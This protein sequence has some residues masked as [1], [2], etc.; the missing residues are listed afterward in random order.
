MVPMIRACFVRHRPY[1]RDARMDNQIRA[2]QSQGHRVD[3]L[4]TATPGQPWVADENGIRIYRLPALQ[5]RRGSK[6]R[7]ALEYATFW[8]TCLVALALLQARRGY[9]LVHV[10][11]LPDFLVWAAI[12]PKLLGARIIL[13]LRECTPEMYH[14]KF[15][16]AMDS[17]AMPWLI[18]LEQSSI[19]FTHLALTCTEQMRARFMER[20]ASR[21]K[22]AVMLN[23]ANPD[24][25]KDPVLPDPHVC[26]HGTLRV[27][28][29]GTITERYGHEV[30]IRAMQLVSREV[31][32]ARLIILGEGGGQHELEDLARAL[33]LQEIVTFCGF[34]PDD[35]LTRQL[36]TAHC[37][38]VPM[39][40]NAE[41]DLIHTYKMVEYMALGI[42]VVASRTTAL[43][44]YYGDECI[45][46]FESGDAADLARALL[47][48]HNDPAR[49]ARWARKALETYQPLAAPA[50]QAHYLE[51]VQALLAEE[52]SPAGEPAPNQALT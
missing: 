38:V 17:R 50:Q 20:G 25:F 46:F 2:L 1:P 43:E 49:R 5:R 45:C 52:A 15:G 35:E 48:L 44:A 11:S 23:V 28:C 13:D 34:V 30:L 4:C 41:T 6:S 24:L 22:V 33:G 32:Q 19:R 9:D 39:V 18:R 12:V 8:L 42:P 7:Y 40:R 47:R 51:L 36:R 14:C 21:G 29:H 10:H 16:L 27:V 26:T 37:G 31:R 3:V